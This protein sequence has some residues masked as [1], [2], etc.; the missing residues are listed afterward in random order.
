MLLSSHRCRS[1]NSV[2]LYLQTGQALAW[3]AVPM[4]AV[5]WLVAWMVIYT[6]SRLI[7]TLGL[8]IVAV[9]CWIC[10]R[11]DSSWAGNSFKIV[12]LL[13]AVGFA[14]TYIGLVSSIVLEGFEAGA[15]TTA[16][17]A[18]TF[19]GFMH[20]IRIFGGQVGV[21]AMAR[22]L[23]LRE[24]FHS[25]LL[26]LHVEA[27]DWLTDQRIGMLSGALLPT[28]TGPAE[29]QSRAVGLLGRQVQAQ[30]YTMA[31]ADGFILIGWIVVVYQLLMLLLRLAKISFKD[32]RSM[33]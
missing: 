7:L 20:F 11:L 21:V 12:E 15:L 8:T 27:G 6:N 17:K 14:C 33:Q 9:G 23:S 25:N 28:S 30:A 31:V 4:F 18:A 26:G 13:L 24:K 2:N 32:L 5:V 29:A 22:F 3:V 10:A 1:E 19:S 16:A